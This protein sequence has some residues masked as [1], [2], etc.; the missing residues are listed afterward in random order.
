MIAFSLTL[1]SLAS[2]RASATLL[3]NGSFEDGGAIELSGGF[4]ATLAAGSTELPGWVVTRETIDYLSDAPNPVG[5]DLCSHGDRCID[6]DGTPGFGGIAQSFATVPG[7]VYQVR[8]DLAGNPG[9]FSETEPHLKLARVLAAG[10]SLD[11]SFDSGGHIP[12]SSLDAITQLWTFTAVGTTTTL[13]FQSLDTA[14]A[15]YSGY[16]GPII[17]H[18]AVNLVPE[19]STAS[20]VMAGGLL[21][22]CHARRLR[23]SRIQKKLL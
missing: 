12:G 22:G 6:L 17:D 3:V 16:F 7:Q 4:Y 10:T 2:A 8:F 13:E 14:E 1:S 18:V 5:D 15:G 23:A 19:P 9:E 20:L 21:I 11:L